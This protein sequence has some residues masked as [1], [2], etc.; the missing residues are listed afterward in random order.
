ME[1]TKVNSIISRAKQEIKEFIAYEIRLLGKE[2]G[3][4][5]DK[6]R[7]WDTIIPTEK[8]VMIPTVRFAESREEGEKENLFY[9]TD[10]IVYMTE[11]IVALD[12]S[13]FVVIDNETKD[14]IPFD[15]LS[16]DEIIFLGNVLELTYKNLIKNKK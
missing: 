7:D 3:V 11:V 4:S 14:E 8:L 5:F 9:M 16:L 12:D 13:I 10:V 1:T 6:K 15:E 2:I